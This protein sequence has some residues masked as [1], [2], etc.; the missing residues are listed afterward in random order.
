LWDRFDASVADLGRAAA[1][2]DILAVAGAYAELGEAAGALAAAVEREDE[3][4]GLLR[5]RA[6]RP[7]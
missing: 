5:R 2:T 7:A 1:G 3:A 6:R 4:S